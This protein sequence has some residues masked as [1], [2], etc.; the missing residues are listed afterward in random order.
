MT[1]RTSGCRA[2]TG[3]R[4]VDVGLRIDEVTSVSAIKHAPLLVEADRVLGGELAE[5]LALVER[6][7]RAV[8]QAR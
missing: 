8:A 4:L 3:T 5:L 6:H 7:A 2:T 1:S